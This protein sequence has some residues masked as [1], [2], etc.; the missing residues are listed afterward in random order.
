MVVVAVVEQCL[1]RFGVLAVLEVAVLVS[2]DGV[3][4]TANTGG[5]GG[6]SRYYWR[7]GNGGNGVVIIA[8]PDT[9]PALIPSVGLTFDQPTR[10]GY[11]V[12]RFTAGTG[13]IRV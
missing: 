10:S 4:G 7:G 12:Y 11:R 5:G 1:D 9:Y 13:T 6:G 8:Y 3:A 2:N